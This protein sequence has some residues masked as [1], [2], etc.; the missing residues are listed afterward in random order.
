MSMGKILRMEKVVLV[1]VSFVEERD[2][3]LV[4]R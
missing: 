4:E 3:S 2:G 1:K